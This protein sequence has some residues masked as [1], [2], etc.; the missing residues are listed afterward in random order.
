MGEGILVFSMRT[1]RLANSIDFDE[2][3]HRLDRPVLVIARHFPDLD[4]IRRALYGGVPDGVRKWQIIERTG[5]MEPMGNVFVQ[6]AGITASEAQSTLEQL[7]L[8]AGIPE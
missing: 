5:P 1:R 6:R 8:H 7:T 2:V 4:A 3:H